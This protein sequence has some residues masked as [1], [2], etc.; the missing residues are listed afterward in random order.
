MFAGSPQL[1]LLG[2]LKL[3]QKWQLY[4]ESL[5]EYE[6]ILSLKQGRICVPFLPSYEA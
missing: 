4:K 3:V 2:R 6:D 1:L 5:W